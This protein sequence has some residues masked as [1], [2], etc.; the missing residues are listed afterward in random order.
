MKKVLEHTESC[1]SKCRLIYRSTHFKVNASEYFTR[2]SFGFYHW[3][4]V[5]TMGCS[6]C[7]NL[8]V[9]LYEFYS[10]EM[11]CHKLNLKRLIDSVTN[12]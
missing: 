9:H 7:F 12:E 5:P 4:G 6:K 1:F 10:S 3:N 2:T 8:G 11:K